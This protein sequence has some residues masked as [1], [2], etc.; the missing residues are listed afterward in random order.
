MKMKKNYYDGQWQED[1]EDLLTPFKGWRSGTDWAL[2][3][4]NNALTY[5]PIFM[6]GIVE[7]LHQMK[8]ETHLILGTRDP[9]GPG[10]NWMRAGV[11]RELGRYDKLG[12]EIKFQNSKIQ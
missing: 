3:A 10:R 1:Y 8:I 2:V 4:W 6:E 12:K 7:K 11:T 5:N 9:T